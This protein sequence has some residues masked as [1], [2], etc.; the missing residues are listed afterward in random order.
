MSATSPSQTNE[1][2]RL[3]YATDADYRERV[4]AECRE[5]RPVRNIKRKHRYQT[6]PE[7]RQKEIER[8]RAYHARKR[9]S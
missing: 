5:H 9:G 1:Y 4:L 7:F 3:R 6:D 8:A 2:R